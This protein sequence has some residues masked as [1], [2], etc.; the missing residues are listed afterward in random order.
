MTADSDLTACASSS[1]SEIRYER[2]FSEY[3]YVATQYFLTC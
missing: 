3:K 1:D 2:A